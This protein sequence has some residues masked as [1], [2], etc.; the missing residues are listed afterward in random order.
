MTGAPD[1]PDALAGL[2]EP[3]RAGGRRGC[4]TDDLGPDE[5]ARLVEQCA[6]LAARGLGGARAALRARRAPSA[7]P[8]RTSAAGAEMAGYPEDLRRRVDAYLTRPALLRRR[9]SPPASRRRCATASWPA[10]S[11][12]ARSSRSRPPGRSARRAPGP[13]VLPF[14]AALELIHTYSLIHDDLPAM[15]D[16]DLRRGRPTCHVAFGEDVAILAGDG[17]L[18]RGLPASC[19]STSRAS[20]PGSSPRSASWRPRRA[21]T[22]WS[23]ASTWTST[24]PPRRAPRD[25]AGCTP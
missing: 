19:S 6:A 22:A 3:P 9:R 11:A 8:G 14:A 12:S 2:V 25:C 15:D 20:P 23:A 10:A 17:A 1:A 21:S 18:R 7:R 4:A 5:A 13:Q 16:D 24:R